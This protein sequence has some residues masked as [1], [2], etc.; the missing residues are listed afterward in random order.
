MVGL[1]HG[2]HWHGS[3]PCLQLLAGA[4]SPI[5]GRSPFAAGEHRFALWP[6]DF[7]F[8]FRG[9]R[10]VLFYRAVLPIQSSGIS[11]ASRRILLAIE[12]AGRE[13]GSRGLAG[14]DLPAAGRIVPCI[15]RIRS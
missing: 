12:Y 3:R 4:A 11:G 9:K 1:E 15:W 14:A 7:R 13:G 5:S 2:P 10:L 6:D 8:A